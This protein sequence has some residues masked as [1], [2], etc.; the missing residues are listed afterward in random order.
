M[1]DYLLFRTYAT[2]LWVAAEELQQLRVERCT[3]DFSR[4][5]SPWVYQDCEV[6]I[7]KFLHQKL[8]FPLLSCE[9]ASEQIYERRKFSAQCRE[10][11]AD[12]ALSTLPST[13]LLT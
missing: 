6:D 7:P 1:N 12:D 4:L 2:Y 11:A 8:G 5:D 13:I 3:S 9:F 10:V